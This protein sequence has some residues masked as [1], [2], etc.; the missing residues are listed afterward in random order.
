MG[1]PW[2]M[3]G[4]LLGIGLKR[5]GARAEAAAE[6]ARGGAERESERP[7]RRG[8]T[9]QSIFG[10]KSEDFDRFWLV[11]SRFEAILLP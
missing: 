6:D 7:G 11:V 8:S 3:L 9:F 5:G 1:N 2:E 10:G 4:R